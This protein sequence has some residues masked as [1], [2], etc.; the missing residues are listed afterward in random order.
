[1]TS[2]GVRIEKLGITNW[3]VWKRQ[4]SFLLKS[5]KLFSA[6]KPDATGSETRASSK[7]KTENSDEAQ[8][9][10]GLHVENYLLRDIEEAESAQA[11]WDLLEKKFEAKDTSSLLLLRQQLTTLRKEPTEAISVYLARARDLQASLTTAGSNVQEAEVVLSVLGGLPEPYAMAV[12]I[13]QLSD[14][15]TFQKILPKL[16]QVEQRVQQTVQ[17]EVFK[18]VPAVQ[19]YGASVGDVRKCFYCNQ[20]GHIKVQCHKRKADMQKKATRVVPAF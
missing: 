1:M 4:M 13:L 2:D 17:Q 5:K 10:I 7:G 18:D 6:V 12:E 19:A 16:L 9:I 3:P 20:P 15:L 14:E 8:G 11:A